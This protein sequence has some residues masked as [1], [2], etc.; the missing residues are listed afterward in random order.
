MTIAMHEADP[1]RPWLV[2][3]TNAADQLDIEPERNQRAG[4]GADP[5]ERYM[6][7]TELPGIAKQQIEAH[8]GD[9]EYAGRDEGIQQIWD[10][11]AT[12]VRRQTASSASQG[13]N[14]LIQFA[15]NARTDPSA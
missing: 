15:P 12:A 8:R 2:D 13:K 5:E 9:D 6:A 11:S 14:R 1:N 10:L 7:E 3:H 4:I